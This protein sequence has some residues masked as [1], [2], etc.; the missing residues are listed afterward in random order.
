M[1]RSYD[2][3]S[4]PLTD[5]Q[6]QSTN[7]PYNS[8]A[9]F[10]G[11]SSGFLP[12]QPRKKR[13]SP[14]IKFGIPLLIIVIAG[15]VVG[16]ILGSRSSKNKTSSTTSSSNPSNPAAASSAAA[17]KQKIGV[18]AVSTD[19]Y[20]LPVYPTATGVSNTT[21][22]HWRY[23]A[24]QTPPRLTRDMFPP[25]LYRVHLEHGPPIVSSQVTLSPQLSAPIALVSLLLNTSG[26]PSPA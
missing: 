22:L 26:T 17:N 14:W 7:N 1:S 15:A 24:S 5:V 9:G 6:Y 13:I 18:F 4:R 3:G 20:G 12:P 21:A 8:G 11:E 25:P 10:Y 23:I 2:S 19:S 16:G